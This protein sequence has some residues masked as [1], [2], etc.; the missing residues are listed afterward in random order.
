[1]WRDE[2]KHRRTQCKRGKLST[3]R[4]TKLFKCNKLTLL[5]SEYRMNKI[6]LP[7][8]SHRTMGKS[9]QHYYIVDA[10]LLTLSY[11]LHD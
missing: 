10:C 2:Q 6:F 8:S 3:Y 1:M 7:R 5:D 11:G 9:E 4:M